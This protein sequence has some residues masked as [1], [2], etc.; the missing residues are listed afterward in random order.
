MEFFVWVVSVACVLIGIYK[1]ITRWFVD[2]D[3]YEWLDILDYEQ[4]KRGRDLCHEME[5]LKG[6]WISYAT[7]YIA[8]DHLE[9]EGLVEH[10]DSSDEHGPLREFRKKSGGRRVRRDKPLETPR[11]VPKFV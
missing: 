6:G 1:F 8:M 4:W 11:T 2:V 5:E 7:V 9:E 10:K 3:K